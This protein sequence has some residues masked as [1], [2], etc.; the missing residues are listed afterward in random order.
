M[1]L[2]PNSLDLYIKLQGNTLPELCRLI[3]P[4]IP[5]IGLPPIKGWEI[6]LYSGMR[7]QGL[8]HK[9][10]ELSIMLDNNNIQ[11]ES[12]FALGDNIVLYIYK[13]KGTDAWNCDLHLY[14]KQHHTDED[15]RAFLN[16]AIELCRQLLRQ[17]RIYSAKINRHGGYGRFCPTIPIAGKTNHLILTTKSEVEQNY[18]NPDVFTECG[19]E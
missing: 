12:K 9:L 4:L 8:E 18:D 5:Q 15:L 13:I 10:S 17:T 14:I 6:P 1:L 16:S 11:D 2:Y 19:V 3:L 7:F